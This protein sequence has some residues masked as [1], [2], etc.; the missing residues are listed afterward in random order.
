MSK[1][2]WNPNGLIFFGLILLAGVSI[3]GLHGLGI[4]AIIDAVLIGIFMAIAA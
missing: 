1:G 3:E 2:N 4:S